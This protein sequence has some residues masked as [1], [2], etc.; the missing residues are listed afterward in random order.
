[1]VVFH[2]IQLQLAVNKGSVG[3]KMEECTL[4]ENENTLPFEMNIPFAFPPRT[5]IVLSLQNKHTP[6]GICFHLPIE[7]IRVV[8]KP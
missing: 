5:L 1:M 2:L 7:T 3:Y 8:A 4:L 6:L